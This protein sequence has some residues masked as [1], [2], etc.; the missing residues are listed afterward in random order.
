MKGIFGLGKKK[1]TE[2]L[3]QSGPQ[4]GKWLIEY[5]KKKCIGSGTCAAVCENH[6]EMKEDG[7]AML[8]GS[9]FNEKTGMFEKFIEEKDF[10]M[11][12]MAAEGCPPNCIHII[13]KETGEKVA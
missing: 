4:Q 3:T 9:R 1:D 11:N 7:K 10:E 12:K 8:I 2:T 6:W 5:D 13:N